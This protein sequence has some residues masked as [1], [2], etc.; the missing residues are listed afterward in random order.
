MTT[1]QPLPDVLS[2]MKSLGY[3]VFDGGPFDLNIVGVR[4]AHPVVN[5]FCDHLHVV[6]RE[7]AGGPW[8]DKVWPVTTDPGTYYLNNPIHVSGTAIVVPGQYRRSHSIGLHRG[9]Y[10]ALVQTGSLKIWLD[11]NR[12]SVLDHTHPVEGSGFGINIHH[13]GAHSTQVDK[14]SAGCQVFANLADFNEFMAIVNQAAAKW[15]PTFTYT[16]LQE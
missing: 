9:D 7:V 14:W 11:S 3:V 13:A 4:S 10:Q 8:V 16:L 15:G 6:Y 12:D 2:K 1:T 5:A